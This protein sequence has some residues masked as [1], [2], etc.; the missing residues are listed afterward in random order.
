M[1]PYATR[2]IVLRDILESATNNNIVFF[3]VRRTWY[4]VPFSPVAETSC[5][6]FS[7]LR[8]MF[9]QSKSSSLHLTSLKRETVASGKPRHIQV[10]SIR[11]SIACTTDPEYVVIDVFDLDHAC[12]LT[13]TIRS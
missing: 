5:G 1:H 11:G 13:R 3:Q 10:H 9:R 4:D 8:D 2:C 7:V 12:R 6:R